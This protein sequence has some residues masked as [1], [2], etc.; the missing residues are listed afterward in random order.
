V[1][2]TKAFGQNFLA[3]PNLARSIA[4]LA[5]VGPRD[6][7]VEV[8]AGVGS[9]TVA[10]AE[11]GARVLAVEL[12]R[13]LV[14]ALRE[15]VG[16]L[17][18]VEILVGDALRLDWGATL[19]GQGWAMVSNLP[20]NVGVP[21]LMRMLTSVPAVDRYL[22]MVQRE[23]G[24]RLAAG[25]GEEAYGS[26]SVRAS[27]HAEIETLR[28]V[29]ASVFWPRP[30]VESILVRLRPRP[31]PVDV[32]RDALFRVVEEGFAERRKTM[33]NALRRLGLDPSTATR[34]LGSCGLLADVRA[35]RL[36]LADFARL[37][38]ALLRDGLLGSTA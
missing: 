7:V 5:T 20:Y 25:P 33:A 14:P 24:E 10:L 11:T 23:V 32:P 6:R 26:I 28:R 2:P 3:D 12:D 29:P 18:N 22:V 37:T 15:V 34:V 8:G 35:E 19:E 36:S 16:S 9:L 31:A 21:V 30:N 38:D 27:Y 1:R 4:A 13:R 17:P